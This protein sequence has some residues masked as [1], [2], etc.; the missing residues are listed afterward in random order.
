MPLYATIRISSTSEISGEY[1]PEKN[2]IVVTK[3]IDGK[4][5]ALALWKYAKVGGVRLTPI[6]NMFKPDSDEKDYT[7]ESAPWLSC[8]T[9]QG[10]SI[11]GLSSS[12]KNFSLS[13]DAPGIN[14]WF[15][16]GPMESL[17]IGTRPYG[18]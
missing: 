14:E 9:I 5:I 1:S 13:I 4:E 6:R 11:D 10:D 3:I 8:L 7:S 18:V 12:D 17:T 15:W 16:N 2:R